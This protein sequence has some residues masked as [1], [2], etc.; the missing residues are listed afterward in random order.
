MSCWRNV[1]DFDDTSGMDI[2]ERCLAVDRF[3][4]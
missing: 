2:R 3:T 4:L 1:K